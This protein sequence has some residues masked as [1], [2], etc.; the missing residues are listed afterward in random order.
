[1]NNKKGSSFDQIQTVWCLYQ[2]IKNNKNIHEEDLEMYKK[3]VAAIEVLS[4][5]FFL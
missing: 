2:Y 3:V 1:M 5:W 4:K